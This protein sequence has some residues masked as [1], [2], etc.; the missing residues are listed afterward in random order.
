MDKVADYGN[1]NRYVA[2]LFGV[3][4]LAAGAMALTISRH[5]GFF[6]SQGA[7][8]LRQFDVNGFSGLVM[9]AAGAVLTAAALG[10]LLLARRA[11]LTVGVVWLGLDLFALVA[12]HRSINVLALH[13]HGADLLLLASV[14]LL[15]SG[16]LLDRPPTNGS[17]PKYR[18]VRYGQGPR[19]LD[20]TDLDRTRRTN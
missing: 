16:L 14:V 19:Y 2:G 8:A 11:S 3:L 7:K 4:W 5:I 9:L 1:A 10:S 20:V 18:T 6:D 13:D 12:G 17:G 15:A